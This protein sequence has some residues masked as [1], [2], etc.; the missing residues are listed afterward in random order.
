MNLHQI[1]EN[2]SHER[3]DI[4]KDRYIK[5]E[6]NVYFFRTFSLEM[7]IANFFLNLCIYLFHSQNNNGDSN[8]A[9]RSDAIRINSILFIDLTRNST[10]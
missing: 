6:K 9:T 2:V 1:R 10:S 8:R 4:D 7:K 3:H 5:Y